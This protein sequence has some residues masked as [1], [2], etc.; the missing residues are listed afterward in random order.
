MWDPWEMDT[1]VPVAAAGTV[2]AAGT[3]APP[4]APAASTA[5]AAMVPAAADLAS[6]PLT[7]RLF[8]GHDPFAEFSPDPF[9]AGGTHRGSGSGFGRAMLRIENLL[10]ELLGVRPTFPHRVTLP[11]AERYS[12]QTA[13]MSSFVDENGQMH[14][15]QFASSD[16]GNS[17]H[18]IRETHQAYSNSDTGV[19]KCALEQHL[20][21]QAVK[22]VKKRDKDAKEDTSEMFLGVQHT[23][24]S[25]DSFNKDFAAKA[26]YLPEHQTFSGDF[27]GFSGLPGGLRM[28]PLPGAVGWRQQRALETGKGGG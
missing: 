21:P 12:V 19:N 23:V 3:A 10:E 17:E 6:A 1:S 7:D 16:V 26:R 8:S 9:S 11:D 15:E 25:K 13:T 20:G 18:N 27:P 4:A 28:P 2:P 14:T 22:T 5:P 24:L